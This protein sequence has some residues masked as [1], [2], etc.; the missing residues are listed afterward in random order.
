MSG[1]KMRLRLDGQP[2]ETSS[3]PTVI[4]YVEGFQ[5]NQHENRNFQL[6]EGEQNSLVLVDQLDEQCRISV[7]VKEALS[8]KSFTKYF[9]GVRRKGDD[10][11]YCIAPQQTVRLYPATTTTTTTQDEAQVN[12]NGNHLA[13]FDSSQLSK[14][15]LRAQLIEKFGSKSTKKRREAI[16]RSAVTEREVHKGEVGAVQSSI[17]VHTTA[18]QENNTAAGNSVDMVTLPPMNKETNLLAEAYPLQAVILP[19]EWKEMESSVGILDS[20]MDMDALKKN[21]MVDMW[22]IPEQ[23]AN[24]FFLRQGVK[25]QQELICCLFLKYL[26]KFQTFPKTMKRR[27]TKV[28]GEESGI[29]NVL[30]ERFLRDFTEYDT[31]RRTYFRSPLYVDKL[32]YHALVVWLHLVGFS[33]DPQNIA[34]L[35]GLTVLR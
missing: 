15:E 3:D 21:D 5:W 4:A 17:S 10:T 35:L 13:A 8:D 33:G 24:D 22:G 2:H 14:A 30:L 12:N 20:L 1:E 6:K 29:P 11:I 27:E 7:G 18:S 25:G 23:L 26:C 32:I 19:R 9:V 31:K 34:E 16:L 28:W